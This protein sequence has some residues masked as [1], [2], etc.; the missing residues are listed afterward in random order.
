MEKIRLVSSDKED[1]EVLLALDEGPLPLIPV[2]E[3]S[4]NKGS[5]LQPAR[6]FVAY[7]TFSK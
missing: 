5:D 6:E 2:P 7:L 3:S 1:K 4:V